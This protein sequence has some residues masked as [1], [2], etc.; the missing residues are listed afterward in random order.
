MKDT[1]RLELQHVNRRSR[2]SIQR[3]FRGPYKNWRA[4][5]LSTNSDADPID[6][7]D[8]ATLTMREIVPGFTSKYDYAWF[9][10]RGLGNG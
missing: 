2:G 8:A 6:A 3:Q 10:G 5:Q 1:I 4:H 9:T 7:I